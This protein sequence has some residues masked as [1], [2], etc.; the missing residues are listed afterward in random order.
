MFAPGLDAAGQ[1]GY[2]GVAGLLEEFCDALRADSCVAMDDDFAVAVDLGEAVGEFVLR[3]QLS[4]DL[5]ELVLPGFAD[6]D[7]LYVFA[8]VD[9]L[10]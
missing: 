6:V 2:A 3:D 10:L 8:C 7:Q 9:A 4:A 5:G 1:V